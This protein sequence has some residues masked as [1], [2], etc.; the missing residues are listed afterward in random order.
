MTRKARN[1]ILSIPIPLVILLARPLALT[2]NQSIILATLILTLTLWVNKSVNRSYASLFMLLV[3]IVFGETPV[4]R[5][6][7]FP[8][9][10]NFLLIIFSFLFSEGIVKSKLI[11]K[12]LKP[13]IGYYA[14][15]LPKL[16]MTI[17]IVALGMIFIVP[18][19]FARLILVATIFREYLDRLDISM[20]SKE[21]LLF[22]VF[23]I[24]IITNTFF[25]KGDI[26][27]H[28]ALINMSGILINEY[29]WT[30][31]LLP[32]G[33]LMLI[34]TMVVYTRFFKSH[35][36]NYRV[37]ISNKPIIRLD[38]TDKVNLILIILPLVFWALDGLHPI[39]GT[40][41]I[42]FG[43]LL[44]FLVKILVFKDLK[45]IQWPL[46]IFLTATFSIGP[47]MLTSG[48][49]NILF[50]SLTP[51]F[52]KEFSLLMILSVVVTS[53]LIHMILGSIVTS[54]SIILPGIALLTTGIMAPELVAF[55][56]FVTLA[57]HFILPFHSVHFVIG[58]GLGFFSQET[59]FRT[60]I[61]MT[62]IIF[63]SIFTLYLPWWNFINLF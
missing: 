29:Q 39:S 40:N 51:V 7:T 2:L 62:G 52:P 10:E 44:M 4:T 47:V 22:S 3:F 55:L 5:V 18:Q 56:V 54:M 46:L 28:P 48:T 26:I 31:F 24:S 43:V 9:S 57:L 41:V 27:M 32:P 45:T 6:L 34:F 14:T 35:L 1:R 33:V 61:I 53:M 16:L 30:K 36:E 58:E 23:L 13:Y 25:L 42:L 20:K 12:L 63:I 60:G 21:L 17:W 59:V 38:S 49:A 15:T 19:P 37:E 50:G 11:D 8:L